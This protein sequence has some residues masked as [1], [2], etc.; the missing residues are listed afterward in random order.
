MTK[1]VI[2][3]ASISSLFHRSFSFL[4]LKF[5]CFCRSESGQKKI[6]KK[7]NDK[8]KIEKSLVLSC[9]VVWPIII[10]YIIINKLKRSQSLS[11]HHDPAHTG[12]CSR[13]SECNIIPFILVLIVNFNQGE[14]ISNS[15]QNRTR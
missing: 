13:L 15:K 12:L 11:T 7:N 3:F 10:Y 9:S 4:V 1:A 8:L 6:R 5:V 2:Y 14:G